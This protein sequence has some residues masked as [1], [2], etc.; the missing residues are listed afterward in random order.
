MKKLLVSFIIIFLITGSSCKKIIEQQQE[1][2][3]YQVITNGRWYV[4]LYTVDATDVTAD[5][6]GYE[7]QFYK[8]NTVDGIKNS[9]TQS[10]T[11][12]GDATAKTIVSAFP[13]AAGDTLKRLTFTWK[14]T[15]SYLDF[16]KAETTTATGKNTL[17][18]RKK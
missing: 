3:L 18:L 17:H 13:A 5:F 8:N 6:L 15:D 4:E 11:W 12:S 16:V 14:I 7:F 10:G 1:D 9:V 2:L